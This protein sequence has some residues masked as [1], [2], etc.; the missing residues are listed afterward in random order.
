MS[1]SQQKIECSGK[2]DVLHGLTK[3]AFNY[4]PVIWMFHNQALNNKIN[5]LKRCLCVIYNDKSSTFNVFIEK[6]DSVSI[7]YRNIQALTIETFKVANGMPPV[8]MNEILQLREESHYNLHCT[9]NFTIPS[10]H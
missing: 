2:S 4:C 10:I 5:R 3:K 1:E 7:H 6:E 9:S 8:I